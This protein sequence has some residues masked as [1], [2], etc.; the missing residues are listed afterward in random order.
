MLMSFAGN[1]LGLMAGC[2]VKDIKVAVGF[3]PT[4]VLFVVLFSGYFKN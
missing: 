2:L 3:V 1:S 4:I